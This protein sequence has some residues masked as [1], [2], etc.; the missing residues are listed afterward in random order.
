MNTTQVCLVR[1]RETYWNMQAVLQVWL[2]S[3]AKLMR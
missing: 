3:F 1:H 2:D